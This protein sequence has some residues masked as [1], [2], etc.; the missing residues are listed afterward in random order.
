MTIRELLDVPL[1]YLDDEPLMEYYGRI[2]IL[3]NNIFKINS[4]L[5]AEEKTPDLLMELELVLEAIDI[6]M[7]NN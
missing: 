6:K 7:S 1:D 5:P 2:A 4:Y 3:W